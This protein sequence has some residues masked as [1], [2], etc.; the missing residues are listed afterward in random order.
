MDPHSPYYPR[1]EAFR[2]MTGRDIEPGRARYLNEF[3]NRS[4]LAPSGF[5]GKRDEVVQ[6]YDAG[7]RWVDRQIARLVEGLRRTNRW[8]DCVFALTADHGEEFLEHGGR[9][10]APVRLV[11]EIVR[12]P[13]LIRVPG[14]PGG[15]VPASPLSHLHLAPTLLESM[16]VAAPSAFRGRS[17]WTNLRRGIAWED[18]AIIE[19]AYGCTNPFRT[20]NRSVP[21]LLG[22]RGNNPPAESGVQPEGD[23]KP[24][25]VARPLSRAKLRTLHRCVWRSDGGGRSNRLW[26]YALRSGLTGG[27]VASYP[28]IILARLHV[29]PRFLR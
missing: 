23:R 6:L 8:D 26:S 17:L 22:V 21:R 5:R 4:D 25:F 1:N 13:L 12:V 14:E 15:K 19:C 18:P 7:I 11:E 16:G 9:Y 3:W 27:G 29:E 10:H 28:S 2:E 24:A 20:E